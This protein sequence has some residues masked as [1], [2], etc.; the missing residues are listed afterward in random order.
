[1][2]SIV[3]RLI[4]RTANTDFIQFWQLL[5]WRSRAL[6]FLLR[7]ALLRIPIAA[8]GTRGTS[9]STIVFVF[10]VVS[11]SQWFLGAMV[12]GPP[13]GLP[14]GKVGGPSRKHKLGS[15]SAPIGPITYQAKDSRLPVWAKNTRPDPSVG[16][17]GSVVG[18]ACLEPS[19]S[20]ACNKKQRGTRPV[21]RGF[22][23]IVCY[24][25]IRDRRRLGNAQSELLTEFASACL[26]RRHGRL[27]LFCQRSSPGYSLSRRKPA[28]AG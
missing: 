20:L 11:P 12:T 22:T 23:A 21:T 24:L 28:V 9:P 19:L 2:V 3:G 1:M 14:W 8:N 18:P 25:I 27:R 15:W 10:L 5:S 17:S 13:S 4:Y 7:S 16:L 26:G 6:G